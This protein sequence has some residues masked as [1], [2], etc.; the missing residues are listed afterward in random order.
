MSW[1]KE[2]PK[3]TITIQ[4][5]QS[6]H[7]GSGVLL[8][9]ADEFCIL[10]AAHVLFD[11]SIDVVNASDFKFMSESYGELIV[12]GESVQFTK[13]ASIDAFLVKICDFNESATYPNLFYTSDHEFPGLKFCFRG[14]PK[15]VS[16]N[17][18]TVYNNSVN[19]SS[20]GKIKVQI[21]PEYYTDFKGETGCEL[22]QGYSGSGWLISNHKNLYLSGIV[23]SVS[24]DNFSGVN[25]I[26][27]SEIISKLSLDIKLSD[28]ED[29]VDLV[30]LDVS[31]IRNKISK[32]I[33]RFAK[34]TNNESVLNLTRKMDLF[35][36]DWVE[37]DL[38]SFVS[39]ML[40]WEEL[41]QSKVIG[42]PK[43]KELI[44]ES[45]SELSSGNKK[46]YV[47]SAIEGN[48]KF[49]EIQAE[50]KSIITSFLDEH[51]LWGKYISTVSNGEIAKYLANCKLD[52]R[53]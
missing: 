21:P 45:K 34:E 43:F 41:Y 23:C 39:D 4:N 52:F 18:Y 51:K 46:F 28:L 12:P 17:I 7:L 31:N 44:E 30:S 5:S 15:S 53:G 3:L 47:A 50:F 37:D 33:I 27:I 19:G 29:T 32:E 38:E 2:L 6:E 35:L 16:G 11:E 8:K 14:K 48:S 36:P 40:I 49:H 9:I 26:C 20:D 13:N 22:L 10:T 25:C 42:N 24:N 1:I